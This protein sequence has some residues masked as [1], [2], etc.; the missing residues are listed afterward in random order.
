MG[1]S[2]WKVAFAFFNL[3]NRNGRKKNKGHLVRHTSRSK[4]MQC[5][6]LMLGSSPICIMDFKWVFDTN[7][8]IRNIRMIPLFNIYWI[9]LETVCILHST[10]DCRYFLF[11][12]CKK[13]VRVLV[14]PFFG[15]YSHYYCYVC[16]SWTNNSS[17]S[18]GSRYYM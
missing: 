7:K 12:L 13:R 18:K 9:T 14:Y 2:R 5:T 10:F 6:H 1:Y 16:V 11:W 17:K 8:S 4:H 15:I 3:Q